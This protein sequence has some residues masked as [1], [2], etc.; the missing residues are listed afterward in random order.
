MP[1]IERWKNVR[2]AWI[3]AG[4]ILVG[5]IIGVIGDTITVCPHSILSS[6]H[7]ASDYVATNFLAQNN[8]LLV[9]DHQYYQLF[10]SILITDS[11]LDAAFNAIAVLVL[12][13]IT[14]DNLNKSRYFIVFV[15]SALIGNLL[16]LLNGPYYSS[17]GASGGI[18]G[19]YA[20]LIIFSFLKDKKIDIPPFILFIVIFVGSSVLPNVNYTAHIGGAIG[21][22]I[23]GALI[24]QSVRPTITEY[25]MAH[26]SKRSTVLVTLLSILL[27]IIASSVQFFNFV[28]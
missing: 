21:G 3:L 19:I 5:W 9:Y 14:E 20:A 8:L 25:S 22:S 16:T 18:F 15:S 13:F 2:P 4:A 10:S 1:I 17:A 7:P 11:P 27:I 28:S 6:C 26:D 24:Y 23:V 12:D